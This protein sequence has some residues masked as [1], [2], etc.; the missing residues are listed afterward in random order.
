ML[1]RLPLELLLNCLS[2]L[3]SSER[4][5]CLTLN[6]T[7]HDL[8]QNSGAFLE[9]ITIE[10][11]ESFEGMC[12][13]F[14]KH[15]KLA[16]FVKKLHI[17]GV[18]VDARS[19]LTLPRLFPTIKDF[20][21]VNPYDP[22]RDYDTKKALAA[23]RPWADTLVSLQEFG[24]PVIAFSL[25]EKVS[26]PQLKYLSLN[27]MGM[28]GDEDDEDEVEM[29]KF[30]LYGYLKNCPNVKIL[31]LKYINIKLSNMEM[32]REFLPSLK[33][34]SLTQV[35]FAKDD[36]KGPPVTPAKRLQTLFLHECTSIGNMDQWLTY[37]PQKYPHLKNLIIGQADDMYDGDLIMQ[38]TYQK[39][40]VKIIKTL[41][42]R[43]E[44]YSA[45]CF[46][47]TSSILHTMDWNGVQLKKIELGIYRAE[48]SFKVLMQSQQIKYINALTISGI[49][50]SGMAYGRNKKKF[51]LNLAK[52]PKLKH[53][54][55]NQSKEEVDP[56]E[57]NRVPL[58][59]ILE[60]LKFLESMQMDFLTLEVARKTKEPFHTKLKKLVLEE[61]YVEAMALKKKEGKNQEE[62][63]EASIEYLQE[64][65]P[66]TEI[67][68]RQLDETPNDEEYRDLFKL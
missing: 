6:K 66:N 60:N 1:D 16:K 68:F 38:N 3:T 31:E 24:T 39:Y 48:E 23:F 56:Q 63:R 26:C 27:L 7:I 54:R 32:L 35:G 41:G 21:F 64:V 42:A 2:Q 25:L 11:L 5:E 20:S 61:C 45:Q 17:T 10:R 59:Y 36:F 34:L 58:D 55:I 57:S 30:V 47:L 43:L 44:Y 12:A 51:V 19:Y 4:V 14:N 37:I 40:M 15:R 49:S 67:E 18:L 28:A 46:K 62:W 8:I 65:L 9:N 53:L 22:V 13:F 33:A 50:Y 52:F 29:Q